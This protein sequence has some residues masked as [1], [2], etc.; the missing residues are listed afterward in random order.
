[1]VGNVKETVGNVAGNT[2]L[3]REGLA[4]QVF[5]KAQNAMGAASDALAINGAPLL[6]L[7]RR[8]IREKP[9]AATA[10]AGLL[11]IVLISTLR[12]RR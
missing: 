10:L 11:G 4:D 12:G 8:F 1:V 3:Q 5:G 2:A 9:L 6:V 7:A